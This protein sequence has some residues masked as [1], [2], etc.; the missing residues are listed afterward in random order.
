MSSSSKSGVTITKGNILASKSHAIVNTV[1]CVG[2]MGKGIALAFKRKYPEMF[3]DYVRRCDRG[4]VELGKPYAYFAKDHVVVNFPTKQHW[5][6]VSRLADIERGLDYLKAKLVEWEVKSIAIPPLGC[7]NGQLD[8]AVVR[9]VLLK[10]LENFPIPV[11]LY[12]PHDE[13][14][15]DNQLTLVDLQAGSRDDGDT[16][17]RRIEPAIMALVE[18]LQV[19][20]DDSYHWPVGRV[21]FQKLAYFATV[22]GIPTELNYVAG[23]YGPFAEG[24]KKHTA[25]L[26]NNGLVSES[27]NGQKIEIRVGD[28]YRRSR[29]EIVR[30]FDPEW[31]KSI[32]RVADLM[33]RFT[34]TQAEIAATVHYTAAV[35]TR[36]FD[37]RPKAKEVIAG[38]EKW[39]VERKPPL[40]RDDIGRSI[41]SLATQGW[42][43]VDADETV[44][45]YLDELNPF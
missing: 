5:R 23:S 34:T 39:K 14:I 11:E 15:E 6:S 21:M 37:R 1:N 10:H 7:G 18:V 22:E 33:S 26:Q 25:R 19:I 43:K 13:I 29:D 30:T 31:R 3:A 44:E 17:S 35:L 20:E 9:P 40:Q 4:E 2:V 16:D 28:S 27:P 41:V 42:I 45:K 32:H 12:V 36:R 38:V 24:L 8:W